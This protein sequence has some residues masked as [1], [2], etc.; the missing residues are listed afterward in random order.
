MVKNRFEVTSTSNAR[1]WENVRNTGRDYGLARFDR[2]LARRESQR[3][4]LSAKSFFPHRREKVNNLGAWNQ[5]KCTWA[6]DR[7]RKPPF[8]HL[9]IVQKVLTLARSNTIFVKQIGHGLAEEKTVGELK[10]PR[11]WRRVTNAFGDG[12]YSILL[13]ITMAHWKLGGTLM[14]HSDCERQ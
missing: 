10:A 5:R 3:K 12:G 2:K 11:C 14:H 6:H 4:I 7:R 9:G 13:A 1:T 8:G